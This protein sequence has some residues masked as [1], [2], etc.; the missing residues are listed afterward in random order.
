ML[1]LGGAQKAAKAATTLQIT[2]EVDIASREMQISAPV[3]YP[4]WCF[5]MLRRAEFK[6]NQL[7]D[8]SPGN[9]IAIPNQGAK[10]S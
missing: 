3:Q 4:E 5:Y 10:P 1:D 7:L 8:R 6:L 9:L 2:I